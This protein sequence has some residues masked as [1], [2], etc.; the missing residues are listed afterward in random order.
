MR[1][2]LDTLESI[3]AATAH[4]PFECPRGWGQVSFVSS[5]WVIPPLFGV[6]RRCPIGGVADCRS[7]SYASNPDAL[8]ITRQLEELERIQEVGTLT[9]DEYTARRRAILHLHDGTEATRRAQRTTAW[10]LAPLGLLFATVG[11]VLVAQVH[12][13]FWVLASAGGVMVAL[14]LSFWAL[15]RSGDERRE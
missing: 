7:C 15:S 11:L 4:S 10:I 8:R 1:W 6:D 2:I 5:A 3:K 9:A 13:G 12:N 14:G